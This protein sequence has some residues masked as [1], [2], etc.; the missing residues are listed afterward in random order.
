[1]FAR[2]GIALLCAGTPALPALAAD[3]EP[4]NGW[5]ASARLGASFMQEGLSAYPNQER[6]PYRFAYH[7]STAWSVAG[8]YRFLPRWRAEL[9][10]AWRSHRTADNVTGRLDTI[11]LIGNVYFDLPRRGSWT[12]Y[13]GAGIGNAWIKLRDYRVDDAPLVDNRARALAWQWTGGV[14]YDIAERWQLTLD[15]RRFVTTDPL[16]TDRAGDI[17]ET[18]VRSRAVMLG[19]ARQL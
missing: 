8:A 7:D 6:P 15:Y 10:L 16:V 3:R 4:E 17:L 19:I 2:L 18:S 13:L 5:D 12:P 1:M 9:E 14:R 11:A